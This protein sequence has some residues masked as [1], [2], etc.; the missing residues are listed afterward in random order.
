ML[1][2]RILLSI[3]RQQVSLPH[4][5]LCVIALFQ[6]FL[7]WGKFTHGGKFHLPRGKVTEP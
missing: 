4:P 6:W 2:L 5:V 1:A 7:T 3:F